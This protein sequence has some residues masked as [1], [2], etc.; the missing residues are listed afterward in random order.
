[1]NN[2][3]LAFSVVFPLI[4]MMSLGYVLRVLKITDIHSLNVMNK[5]IFRV[6]LPLLLF[7]NIYSLN[8]E[9]I[10]QKDMLKLLSITAIS[11]VM[12]I[13]LSYFLFSSFVKDKRKCSVMIQGVFRSN[14]ILFGIPISASIY[15]EGK[16]GVVSLLAAFIVPLFNILAVVVLELHRGN[17]LNMKVIL[18]SI[19]KNPLIIAS[20]CAFLLLYLKLELPTLLLSPMESMSKVATPLAFVVLGGTFHFDRVAR[21]LKYLTAVVLGKL[22]VFPAIL[23][24][25]AIL[26]GF[27]N[28]SIVA[29]IGAIASPTAISSF[30]MAMEMDADGELAGQIVVITSIISIITIFLWVFTLK[31]AKV[32]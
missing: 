29:L 27:R 9:E 15:G 28:E 24:L 7:L 30:N 5:L 14:L 18:F 8:I 19:L 4:V 1:M 2:I 20:L 25:V 3:I 23:F 31:S 22:I 26:M 10:F 17:K 13:L 21:N 12:A 16:T 11:I 6:F 32:I